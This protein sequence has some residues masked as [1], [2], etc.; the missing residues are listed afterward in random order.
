MEKGKYLTPQEN[1][2]ILLI[3]LFLKKGNYKDGP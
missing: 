1:Q 3:P 2:I